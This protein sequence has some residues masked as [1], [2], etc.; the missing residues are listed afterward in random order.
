MQKILIPKND[1][2]A[3]ARL[4]AWKRIHKTGERLAA[5][6]I[7]RLIDDIPDIL[8]RDAVIDRLGREDPALQ[9]AD[10]EFVDLALLLAGIFPRISQQCINAQ[11]RDEKT[12]ASTRVLFLYV[13][14][15]FCIVLQ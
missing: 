15:K 5:R 9:R 6:V 2:V 14:H 7:D 10:P 12:L 3:G 13:L 8:Q 4:S 1:P 11:S